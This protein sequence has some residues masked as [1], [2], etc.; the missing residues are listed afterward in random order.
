MI[1]AAR[2]TTGRRKDEFNFYLFSRTAI[3]LKE[4][5]ERCDLAVFSCST[6]KGCE[7]GNPFCVCAL[8]AAVRIRK[9]NRILT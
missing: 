5:L 6:K 9:Q 3:N 8:A 4:N 2:R 1:C 7:G